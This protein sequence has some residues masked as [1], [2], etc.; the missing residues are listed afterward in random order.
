MKK[1]S[2][3]N[4]FH[5]AII[6]RAIV[7]CSF[8]LFVSP[9]FNLTLADNLWAEQNKIMYRFGAFELDKDNYIYNIKSNVYAYLQDRQINGGWTNEMAKEFQDAYYYI[10]SRFEDPK[11]PN[12]FYTD[13]FGTL[14]DNGGEIGNGDLDDFW[15]DE[16][17]NQISGTEYRLLKDKKKTKYHQFNAN[18][19]VVTYMKK[20]GDSLVKG[21]YFKK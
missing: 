20:I 21:K 2:H 16:K 6:K 10:I 15:Y 11:Q 1:F 3:I 17:G 5:E 9:H 4:L 18:G 8:C 14:H 7:F 12:R 13:E 19:Q